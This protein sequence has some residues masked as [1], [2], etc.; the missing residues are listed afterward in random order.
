MNIPYLFPVTSSC[1]YLNTANCGA[2]ST[3]AQEWRRSY[4]MGV[5]TQG[6]SH[7]L[8]SSSVFEE[9]RLN[10]AL[11]F[12]TEITQILLIPNFT[13]GFNVL[14]D[15]LKKDHRFLLLEGDFPSISYPVISR[16]FEHTMIPVGINVED[17]ILKAIAFYKPTVLA[18]SIVQ[19][20]SG[21]RLDPNVFK[22][23][24]EIYP[25]VLLIAD[26]TQFCGTAPF[27]FA[28]SGLDAVLS[29][30]YKWML[31][32]HGNG[33]V[34]LSKELKAQLYTGRV[35]IPLPT[36]DFMSNK[37]SLSLCFE[38]G[39]LDPLNFGSLNQGVRLLQQYGLECVEGLAQSVSNRAR[40]EFHLRGLLSRANA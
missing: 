3:T 11:L 7:R 21:I 36:E 18:F 16:K 32:G 25:Q 39:H 12:G 33:F 15:G 6:S 38:P 20:I 19:Y 31:G 27:H 23:I 24:K 30:G 14:L 40:T 1:T 5:V 37:D 34:M 13:F 29:S 2:L 9:L 35:K 26:G 28:T 17:D 22:R 8:R 4:D 10:L